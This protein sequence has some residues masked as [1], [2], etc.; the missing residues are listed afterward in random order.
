MDPVEGRQRRI[1]ELLEGKTNG[2]ARTRSGL[3]ETST[4]ATA[5]DA[6]S[7]ALAAS[8]RAGHSHTVASATTTPPS[9]AARPRDSH[10]LVAHGERAL[11]VRSV[12][13]ARGSAGASMARRSC[14][15]RAAVASRVI[16]APRP[17]AV[18]G[19]R[20]TDRAL[21]PLGECEQGRLIR[22]HPLG[23]RP[24]FEPIDRS[25][26]LGGSRIMMA[27]LH[28]PRPPLWSPTVYLVELFVNIC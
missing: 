9:A 28:R 14:T 25:E 12:A 6:S 18:A 11:V 24:R 19:A 16:A 5:G 1:L 3:N 23:P 17:A 27:H 10:R 26:Q 13:A 20:M 7:P 15:R 8:S 4:V 2:Y 21:A 22:A